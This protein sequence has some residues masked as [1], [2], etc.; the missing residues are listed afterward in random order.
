MVTLLWLQRYVWFVIPP[1]VSLL[2]SCVCVS[3][4][5]PWTLFLTHSAC[6][7]FSMLEK[8][9]HK[10]MVPWFSVMS[11]TAL[12]C[13]EI[14]SRTLT[15][16]DAVTYSGLDVIQIIVDL[17]ACVSY[18]KNKLLTK[19]MRRTKRI[20]QDNISTDG[21]SQKCRTRQSIICVLV[22]PQWPVRQVVLQQH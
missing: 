4:R 8:W 21:V 12:Y 7:V 10:K 15:Q 18:S 3:H 22:C 20:A 14:V 6:C 1:K 2:C 11:N 9:Q 5:P 13:N 19:M 17:H 16:C